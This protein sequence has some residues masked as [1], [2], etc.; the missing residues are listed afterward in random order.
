MSR[1]YILG[2]GGCGRE[3]ASWLLDCACMQGHSIAGF[4]D[5]DTA[6]PG[7]VGSDKD[8]P[9]GSDDLFVCGV[10]DPALKEI[11]VAPL[12]ARGATF[13]RP[14]HPSAVI[15]RDA[16]IGTG[17]VIGWNA[18]V[19]TNA[20]VGRFVTVVG[21]ATIGHDAV[22]GDF[23]TLCCHADLTGHVRLTDGVLVGSHGTVL[24][25][26]VVGRRSIV[27]AG[28]VVTANVPEKTTVFGV[29]ATRL[30]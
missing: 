30:R 14:I 12:L 23:S 5:T 21:S 19:S 7:V 8:W 11:V 2:A 24:P 25:G 13:L 29:P 6:L 15:A 17:S 26:V 20:A 27:G 22:V 1:V 4:L 9:V 18:V 10:S 3:I 16:A 28:A